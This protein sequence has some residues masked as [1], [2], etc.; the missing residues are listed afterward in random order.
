PPRHTLSLHDALPISGEGTDRCL[1]ADERPRPHRRQLAD[2]HAVAGDD[3]RLALIEGAHDAPAVIAKLA[4]R[5]PASH[6]VY[7]STCA[8]IEDRKSTRLNSSHVAI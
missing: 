6:R 3:E 4:L 5:N 8:T 1:G 2:R 7:C